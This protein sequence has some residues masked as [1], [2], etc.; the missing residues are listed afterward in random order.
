MKE[1]GVHIKRNDLIGDLLY[2]ALCLADVGVPNIY[3]NDT[4]R[5]K[6]CLGTKKKECVKSKVNEQPPQL[7]FRLQKGEPET[8]LYH[9]A[10]TFM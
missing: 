4:S 2:F 10:A 9:K 6:K 7:S 8:F 1:C 3:K 5:R